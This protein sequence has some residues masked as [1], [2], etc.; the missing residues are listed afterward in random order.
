MKNIPKL[1]LSSVPIYRE[2]KLRMKQA[3]PLDA[4]KQKLLEKYD[5]K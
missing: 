4:I 5:K 3:Y 1:V 2:D